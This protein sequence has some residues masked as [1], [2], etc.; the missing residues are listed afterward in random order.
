MRRR[1]LRIALSSVVLISLP[2]WADTPP[3]VDAS[4]RWQFALTPYVWLPSVDG[5]MR[6]SL[7]DNGEA[8]ASTGPYNYFQNIRFFA[9]L[10]GEARKGDWSIFADAIY[11][12]FGNHSATVQTKGSGALERQLESSGETSFEGVLIQL[13]GG[14]TV[15]QLSRVTLDAIVGIRYL[16]VRS[17]LD[18]SRNTTAGGAG[19]G[20][21]PE[22]HASQS[23]D[24]YDGFIGVRGRVSLTGD[25]RW[26]VPFYLD[27]GT[28]TSDFTWQ[29]ASGIA[30]AMKW[31]DVTL[32]YRYLAFYGSGD[33]LVQ[34]LRF[35]GPVLS[36]TFRF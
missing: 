9:M 18:V 26:Y 28:G 33:Q 24:I 35:K 16:G 4:T 22:F 25:G 30:Y 17:S 19:P 5:S 3:I 7:P 11:L 1:F 36:A 29:A 10:Q 14:H 32:S 2:A 27:V 20:F 34:S 31:G 21:T 8:D 15:V 13:G 23:A 12:N 6:F